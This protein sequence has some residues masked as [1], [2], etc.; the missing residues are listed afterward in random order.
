MK[1]RVE[2]NLYFLQTTHRPYAHRPQCSLK[3]DFNIKMNT[4]CTS[5]MA[6]LLGISLS[7]QE[8]KM[9]YITIFLGTKVTYI[10]FTRKLTTTIWMCILGENPCLSK[11]DWCV[12]GDFVVTKPPTDQF[13]CGSQFSTKV[14]HLVQ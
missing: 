5:P 11:V 7:I 9:E 8:L 12:L 3:L 2:L 4:V 13:N 14:T 10:W 6:Q 1:L